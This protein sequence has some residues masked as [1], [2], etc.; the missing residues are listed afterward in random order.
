MQTQNYLLNGG[1]PPQSPS[2]ISASAISNNSKSSS[3]PSLVNFPFVLMDPKHDKKQL[4]P[5]DPSPSSSLTYTQNNVN[6]SSSSQS[7][8]PSK[9]PSDQN[10][11]GN[12]NSITPLRIHQWKQH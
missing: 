8:T 6:S 9:S 5:A 2:I 4:L 10:K 1:I 7:P 3:T 12:Q 11:N